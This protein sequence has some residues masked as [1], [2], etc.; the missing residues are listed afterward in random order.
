MSKN[1]EKNPLHIVMFPWLA[2]GHMIPNLERAKLL[3]RGSPREFRIHPKKYTTSPQTT[4]I[5]FVQLP[6]PKVDNLPEHEE[7]T[8]EVPYDVVPFL[9][10]AYDALEEP[11]THFLESS[12]P[13]WVFYDF[14]PFWTG[15][16]AS[17][18]G[19]ESVFFSILYGQNLKATLSLHCGCVSRPASH[20]EVSRSRESQTTV[21]AIAN[22]GSRT[23]VGWV[24]LSRT[25][26]LSP[27][28]AVP[29]LNLSGFKDVSKF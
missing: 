8:S 15:S 2:F 18:L 16:A 6:L 11:L 23:L 12:K 9:K 25:T 10:T 29:N 28:E 5:K 1:Q 27:L 24:L 19:M 22:P 21:W 3:K 14:V 26:I 13:D 4:L 17:K 20:F 7:A